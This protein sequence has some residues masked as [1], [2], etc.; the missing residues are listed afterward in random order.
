G[1]RIVHRR[2]RPDPDRVGGMN[3]RRVAALGAVALAAGMLLTAA[4][5]SPTPTASAADSCEPGTINYVPE[6]PPALDILDAENAHRI[7]T[8]RGVVVAVVDSGI[9]ASNPHL[10]DAVIGGVNLVGDDERSDGLSDVHGHGT[11]VAGQIAARPVAGS[12]V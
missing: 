10:A 3:R 7:A 9:D 6:A 1:P 8:G 4:P 5:W 11:V 2:R 12:G